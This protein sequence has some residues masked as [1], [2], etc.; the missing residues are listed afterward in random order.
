M[1]S[2]TLVPYIFLTLL[3]LVR[4]E[5]FSEPVYEA[6]EEE[7]ARVTEARGRVARKVCGRFHLMFIFFY[8]PTPF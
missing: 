8:A 5:D 6:A 4:C 1:L 2:S 3:S 7:H